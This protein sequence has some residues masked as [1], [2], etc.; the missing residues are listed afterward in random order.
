VSL[1]RALALKAQAK[2]LRDERAQRQGERRARVFDV[3]DLLFARQLEVLELVKRG[4]YH[5]ICCPRRSGK[6]NFVVAL[7]FDYA[8]STG[9]DV[10]YVGL[11]KKAA[12]KSVWAPPKG[13][14]IKAVARMLGGKPNEQ[15]LSVLLPNGA[16]VYVDGIKDD[17]VVDRFR[18]QSYA[19]VVLDECQ[20]LSPDI[21]ENAVE[22]VL[23]PTISDNGG[24]LIMC[25]TPSEFCSGLFWEVVGEKSHPKYTSHWWSWEDN[26]YVRDTVRVDAEARRLQYGDDDPVYLRE[27]C[28]K[29]VPDKGSLC[30][31]NFKAKLYPEGNLYRPSMLPPQS[32]LLYSLI[33][34]DIGGGGKGD[35][36]AVVRLSVYRDDPKTYATAVRTIRDGQGKVSHTQILEVVEELSEG[37]RVV[38]ASVDATVQFAPAPGRQYPIDP[39]NKLEKAKQIAQIDDEFFRLTLLVPEGT[40]LVTELATVFWDPKAKANHKKVPT[41][42]VPNDHFDAFQYAHHRLVN[43]QRTPAPAPSI[44]EQLIARE[45]LAAQR[46]ERGGWKAQLVGGRRN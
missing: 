13:L 17:G 8:L 28:G 39:A 37:W 14:G 3:K 31:P 32:A 12:K 44:Q 9:L 46:A 33:G 38:A 43:M 29:W 42:A 25:G 11:T 23:G 24:T 10:V 21:I 5:G 40:E 26:P 1:S 30:A 35:P 41:S 22:R 16:H 36:S 7:L 4:R 34:I 6:T 2:R 27:F 20:S 18:G 19:L 15:E 45:K